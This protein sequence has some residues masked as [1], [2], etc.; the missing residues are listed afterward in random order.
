MREKVSK[1][2]REDDEVLVARSSSLSSHLSRG[3]ERATHPGED[4][5][6]G[7][8]NL[9]TVEIKQKRARRGFGLISFEASSVSL[10]SNATWASERS[11]ILSS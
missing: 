5:K 10:Q 9:S 2:R 11:Q 7:L 8:V 3:K 4:R 1:S 6:D